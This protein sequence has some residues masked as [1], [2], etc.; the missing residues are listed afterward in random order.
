V[1]VPMDKILKDTLDSLT[2]ILEQGK[3]QIVPPDSMPEV[4][5]DSQRMAE[6]WQ[7][8]IENSVK[9]MGNQPHPVIE[10]GYSSGDK[11]FEFYV[12]DN[13]V[14]I[15]KKYFDTV[16]GLFNKLDNKSE[17]TGFGLAL[18][19]RIIE[20]HGGSIR[21]ESMGKDQGSTFRFTLPKLK[22][23]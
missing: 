12:R 14:G 7:N 18:V 9:F 3:V 21:V 19:K 2:G 22:R 4:F 15:E 16:F 1:K 13:G 10:V 11:F 20:I 8:L 6:V 17:G 23:K 5:V